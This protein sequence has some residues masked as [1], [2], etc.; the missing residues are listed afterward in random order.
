MLAWLA[1]S[2]LSGMIAGFVW[3]GLFFLIYGIVMFL[4]SLWGRVRQHRAN[5]RLRKWARPRGVPLPIQ[6]RSK[7]QYGVS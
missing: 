1:S 4:G 7:Q 3:L 2:W 5:V 6:K